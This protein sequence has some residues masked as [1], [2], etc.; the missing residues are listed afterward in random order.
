MV[1]MSFRVHMLV[2]F[3]QA[4]TSNDGLPAVRMQDALFIA[5]G[6]DRFCFLYRIISGQ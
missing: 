3:Q 1:I 2:I 6:A 5:L 4:F